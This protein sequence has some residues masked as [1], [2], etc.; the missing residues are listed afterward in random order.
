MAVKKTTMGKFVAI[1][2]GCQQPMA[3]V[4]GEE[5]FIIHSKTK[6]VVFGTVFECHACDNCV[7]IGEEK[8]F[9]DIFL[10]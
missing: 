6:L 3:T 10:K 2:G 9:N 1:C 8:A 5:S 4:E 7:T